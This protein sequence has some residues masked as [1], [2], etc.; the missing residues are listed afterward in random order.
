V[1]GDSWACRAFVDSAVRAI[2]QSFKYFMRDL[3]SLVSLR[4]AKFSSTCERVERAA[5]RR[6][7]RTCDS[8]EETQD[9]RE[10]DRVEVKGGVEVLR[11]DIA[12]VNRRTSQRLQESNV[13]HEQNVEAEGEAA[14]DLKSGQ[15]SSYPNAREQINE[16]PKPNEGNGGSD[17]AEECEHGGVRPIEGGPSLRDCLRQMTSS[18]QVPPEGIESAPCG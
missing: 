18:D 9:Q 7:E 13:C 1:S 14:E 4:T 17:S 6:R 2:S 8:E 11:R 15:L 10:A 12:Y 5:A 3:R 16:D